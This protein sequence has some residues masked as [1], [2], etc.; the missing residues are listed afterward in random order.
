MEI[1]NKLR[2]LKDRDEL[3]FKYQLRNLLRKK[4]VE[5]LTEF[6]EVLFEFKKEILFDSFFFIDI[7]NETVFYFYWN[8]QK[9]EE[10]FKEIIKIIDITASIGDR[11]TLEVLYYILKKIPRYNEFYPKLMNYYGSIE[12]KIS[13]LE[14][15][16][17]KLKLHPPKQ[18]IV[19][20]YE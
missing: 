13:Y 7:L 11:D 8:N 18:M 2:S 4:R 16:V 17:S 6:T 9:D 10:L 20:W 1:S 15:K 12:H 5:G 14:Q 3:E 19:K